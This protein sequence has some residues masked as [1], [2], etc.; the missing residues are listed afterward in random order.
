MTVEHIK[1]IIQ[2]I[3]EKF[4]IKFSDYREEKRGGKVTFV[5]YTIQF[6]VD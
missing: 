3:E 5:Y 2:E 6:K 1:K 4:G